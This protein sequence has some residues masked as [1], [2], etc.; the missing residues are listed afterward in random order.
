MSRPDPVHDVVEEA[1]DPT[2]PR[3]DVA[4]VDVADVAPPAEAAPRWLPWLGVCG[5]AG[6][7]VLAVVAVRTGGAAWPWDHTV[8]Q[9]VLEHRGGIDASVARAVTWGGAT[10]VALPALAVAGALL[11]PGRRGLRRRLG[12]GLLLSGSAALCVWLGLAVNHA[13]G[14]E[15]PPVVDWWGAAGGP[16]F[17]S[18]HTT[19]ATVVAATFAWAAT[20]RVRSARGRTLVWCTAAA[21][22][23][24]VG[25]SRVWLGVHWPSD[26]LAGWLLAASWVA[27][28]VA[29]AG[30]AERRR[31]ARAG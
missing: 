14:R 16:S 9:W 4:P 19:A 6:A 28:L 23:L 7:A 30:Y 13:V 27:L 18:G 24:A 26:V 29:G 21:Y 11:P 10:S 17:P 31:R 22:A 15:R 2:A 20:A 5:A 8:H 12:A 1:L 25:W 3:L